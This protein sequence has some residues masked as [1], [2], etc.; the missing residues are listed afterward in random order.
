MHSKHNK[1]IICILAIALLWGA[2]GVGLAQESPAL[3]QYNTLSEYE[4][5]TGKV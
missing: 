1:L 5:V 3:L 4:E 2:T